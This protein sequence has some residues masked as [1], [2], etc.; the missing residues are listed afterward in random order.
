V[1]PDYYD[2]RRLWRGLQQRKTK[3]KNGNLH[4]IIEFRSCAR[5]RSASSH[6]STKSAED[7]CDRTPN[8]ETEKNEE[9]NNEVL[10]SDDSIEED[11]D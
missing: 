11:S 7:K 9:I 1:A 2:I 5:T 4:C 8:I 6:R 3:K 10:S